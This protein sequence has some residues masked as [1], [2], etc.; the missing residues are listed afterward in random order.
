MAIYLVSA[1]IH[2]KGKAFEPAQLTLITRPRLVRGLRIT[3]IDNW[4]KDLK[5]RSVIWPCH[6]CCYSCCLIRTVDRASSTLSSRRSIF[7]ILIGSSMDI[8]VF[9]DC[10]DCSIIVIVRKARRSLGLLEATRARGWKGAFM[11]EIFL[12]ASPSASGSFMAIST[13]WVDSGRV[14]R[15]RWAVVKVTL[16]QCVNEMVMVER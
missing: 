2:G 7:P 1:Q 3:C 15:E 13:M 9:G 12:K 14:A 10:K 16:R 8:R 11:F 4:N 6:N 5:C